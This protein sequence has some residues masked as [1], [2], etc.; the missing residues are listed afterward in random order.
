MAESDKLY[1]ELTR[2]I[3]VINVAASGAITLLTVLSVWNA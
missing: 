2:R 3:G 1:I